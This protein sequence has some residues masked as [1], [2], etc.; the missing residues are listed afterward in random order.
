VTLGSSILPLNLIIQI[1]LLP[2][3]LLL[4]MGSSISFNGVLILK[5]IVLVLI[6]PLISAN[7]IK[8]IVKRISKQDK[9]KKIG[10]YADT[11]QLLFLCLAVIAMFASQGNLLFEN[12]RLFLLIFPPLI[13]FFIVNF[14][15]AL[16]TGKAVKLSFDDTIPLVFTTAARNS[17]VSLAI[18]AVTFPER[19][20]IS[21]VLVIGPLLEIP[22]LAVFANVLKTLKVK[23]GEKFG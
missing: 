2:V 5:S 17:P 1:L 23:I 9:L 4:F 14:F 19:P 20:I 18:A 6:I 3:Y 12:G 16:C 10:A 22:V 11:L 13:L 15:L 7:V 21:L 8:M